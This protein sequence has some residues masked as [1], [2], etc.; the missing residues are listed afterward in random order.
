[1]DSSSQFSIS[2]VAAVAYALCWFIFLSVVGFLY[3]CKCYVIDVDVEREP[4]ARYLRGKQR[5]TF[6]TC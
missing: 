2:A 6:S 1:M 4:P 3:Y 5:P